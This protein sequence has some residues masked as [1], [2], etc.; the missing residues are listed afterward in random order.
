MTDVNI[1]IL[2]YEI[3]FFSCNV[4]QYVGGYPYNSLT[5]INYGSNSV[6]I[7]NI[8]L[9]PNQQLEI[10]GNVGEITTQRFFVNFVGGTTG[11]VTIIRKRY[12]N[13]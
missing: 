7:E 13:I 1:N 12:L 8:T 2:K 5:F 6:N 11:N 10:A 9:Q 3:D 4:S